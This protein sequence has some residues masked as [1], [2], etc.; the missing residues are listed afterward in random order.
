MQQLVTLTKF[1]RHNSH[2]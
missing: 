1:C 2:T